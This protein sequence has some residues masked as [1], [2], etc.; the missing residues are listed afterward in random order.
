MPFSVAPHNT[1]PGIKPSLIAESNNTFWGDTDICG[2]AAPQMTT[3]RKLAVSQEEK[4]EDWSAAC[5]HSV[6]K[7]RGLFVFLCQ[8]VQG[9]LCLSS[10]TCWDMPLPYHINNDCQQPNAWKFKGRGLR[11]SVNIQHLK[12]C[13]MDKG[14]IT[15]NDS[16]TRPINPSI[17]SSTIL[18]PQL[19]QMF[20]L[21][22][23]TGP[24]PKRGCKPWGISMDVK[25]VFQDCQWYK[26]G[27]VRSLGNCCRPVRPNPGRC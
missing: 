17:K 11:I 25:N 4:C 15:F 19:L 21:F 7:K 9:F 23:L 24:K 8:P 2:V 16:I 5:K 1:A 26:E 27:K 20:S 6:E 22:A 3:A 14:E 13:A 12:P 10:N 18:P